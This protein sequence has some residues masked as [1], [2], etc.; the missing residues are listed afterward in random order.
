M[1]QIFFGADLFDGKK[2][3]KDH[4]LLVENGVIS[5]L[6]P[7]SERP[8][9]GEAIDLSGGILSPGFI[10]VQVNG[11]GGTLFNEEPTP[12]GIDKIAKAHRR[13]GTTSLLPTVITD[14]P[15]ILD[16]ALSAGKAA[17]GK[18]PGVLG[19]HVEGPFIDPVKKGAHPAEFIRALMD[20]D[21]KALAAAK[22]GVLLLTIAP[23]KVRPDHIRALVQAGIYVSLGHSNATDYEAKHAFDAG[24]RAVTHLFNAMSQCDARAPGLVGATLADPRVICGLIA[25]GHHVA[26]TAILA[27]LAAKGPEGIALISDAMPSA[28]GG[29]DHFTLQGREVRRENNRLTLG[30]GTLAGADITLLDAVHYALSIGISLTDILTMVTST[31]A[32]MIGLEEKIGA[33]R[34]GMPADLVHL[35]R[36]HALLGVYQQG[37]RLD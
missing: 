9:V 20:A 5:A 33:L 25:D 23:N 31:P 27:A 26:P 14:S 12:E 21:I 6:M 7:V 15:K 4:A 30:S 17:Y 19:L 32:R 34:P 29:P 1:K 18:I 35:G 11:G 10:D 28:A 22:A 3:L 37:I 36:D 8:R 2:I 24:A 13:F 16:E